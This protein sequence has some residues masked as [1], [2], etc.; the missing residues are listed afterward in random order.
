LD[1]LLDGG[2]APGTTADNGDAAGTKICEGGDVEFCGRP[3]TTLTLKFR[4]KHIRTNGVNE[5]ESIFAI[6][7][8]ISCRQA[9]SLLREEKNTL[10]TQSSGEK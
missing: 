4:H 2:G 10:S 9:A 5:D 1:G 7:L 8:H 6:V 3:S